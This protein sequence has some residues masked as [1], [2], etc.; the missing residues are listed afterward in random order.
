MRPATPAHHRAS[1]SSAGTTNSRAT[2]SSGR[3]A[4]TAGCSPGRWA[5]G[6][7]CAKDAPRP[8][9]APGTWWCSPPAPRIATASNRAPTTG[10]SGGR[11]AEPDR[12]GPPG[13]GR[14]AGGTA[15]MSSPRTPGDGGPHVR[16]EAAFRRM[17]ADARWTGTGTPP[18]TAPPDD[19]VAV[20]VAHG[21]T[22]RELALGALEEVVL[23]TAG[24]ARGTRIPTGVDHRVQR[25]QELIA[26]DPGAPHTVRSLAVEVSLS[27]S[28]FAHLFTQQVSRS[29]M[30]ALREAR[31][32]HAARLLERTD[33]SVERVAA[34]S[35][36]ASPFHFNRVFRD[37][38]GTP[39]GA[40]R[41]G[42]LNG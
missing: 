27:P 6:A 7:P 3:A 40:Y 37:R 38:Y 12:P 21:T 15:C 28:R 24:A 10:S 14:T 41:A 19:R 31:L 35:G 34:A 17:L 29:P 5:A 16:I 1:W 30:R 20:A 18:D 33:L 25:A 23:L 4:P 39:P 13:W 42:R 26:A 8:G 36:F 9:P 32:H 2:P 22:A 11:T